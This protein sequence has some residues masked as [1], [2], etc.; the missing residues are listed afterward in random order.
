MRLPRAIRVFGKRLA[1]AGGASAPER[2]RVVEW[3]GLRSGMR[4]A[5]IGAGFGAWA[6]AFAR[7]V[8]PSGS[9]YALDTDADLREEVA[10]EAVRQGLAQVRPIEVA[11]D[12]PD[13]P[14]PVDL[15]FLSASFHHLPDRVATWSA[16]AT[17]SGPGA[18]VVI[19]ES[20]P[21]TGLRVPGHD[22][23]PEQVRTTMEAAGYRLV[24]TADLVSGSSVQAYALAD[25]AHP[26]S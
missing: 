9:V 6:F 1:Y 25:P 15:A 3:L 5:D 7:V 20:R 16:S 26:P 18:R 19:I 14:E 13:L 11:P 17:S 22:T 10:R 21:G 2:E 4:I 24:D 23:A 8:G 12:A